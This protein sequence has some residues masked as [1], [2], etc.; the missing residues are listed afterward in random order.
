MFTSL[1]RRLRSRPPVRRKG[2][3][4]GG[5][6]H[7]SFRPRLE[8]LE[9]RVLPAVG[10]GGAVTTG[11]VPGVVSGLQQSAIM[12]PAGTRPIQVT[13]AGNSLPTVI[14]LGP[15][16][17]AMG[18]IRQGGDLKIAIVGNTNPGLVTA[19]LSEAALTLTYAPRTS[20]T[21][22]ITVGATDPDGVSVQQTLQVTVGPLGALRTASPQ[23]P[24]PSG[25]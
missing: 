6:R 10:T 23:L 5:G 2:T 14:D 25:R 4:L 12:P 3:C 13:V 7:L 9:D 16:F 8:S 24:G 15:V 11:A 20:G 21:A 18:G 22:T 19:S 17:A 1:W